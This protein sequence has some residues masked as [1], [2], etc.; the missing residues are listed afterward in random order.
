MKSN[1]VIID[2]CC[3]DRKN[4]ILGYSFLCLHV[5][6][7]LIDALL[8]SW[9]KIKWKYDSTIYEYGK[10]YCLIR[11]HRGTQGLQR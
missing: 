1:I 11:N 2:G 7:V 4:Y 5:I 9:C 3:L 8:W 10:T 6:K